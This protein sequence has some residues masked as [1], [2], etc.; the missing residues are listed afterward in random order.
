[1]NFKMVSACCDARILVRNWGGEEIK[2]CG[3]CEKTEPKE[4]PEDQ[5]AFDKAQKRAAIVGMLNRGRSRK[6]AA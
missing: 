3:K 6:K 2:V 5:E 4:V 1:M